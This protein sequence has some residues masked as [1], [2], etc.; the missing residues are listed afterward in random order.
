[1]GTGGLESAGNK[2]QETVT[3][4]GHSLDTGLPIKVKLGQDHTCK[5]IAECESSGL[6]HCDPVEISLEEFERQKLLSQF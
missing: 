4:C 2:T 6:C 1:M 3:V 5:L